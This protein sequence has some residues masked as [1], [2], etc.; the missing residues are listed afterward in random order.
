[1]RHIG[2]KRLFLKQLV[3]QGLIEVKEVTASDNPANIL[4][5]AVTR[6]GLER[7]LETLPLRATCSRMA[8]ACAAMAGVGE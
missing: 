5:K 8:S 6:E 7:I 3:K 4:T 1:M 2:I